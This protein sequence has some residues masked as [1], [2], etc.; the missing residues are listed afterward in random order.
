MR[1][2]VSVFA[3]VVFIIGITSAIK[4]LAIKLAVLCQLVRHV[5]AKT[6]IIWFG[7]HPR[8]LQTPHTGLPLYRC[9]LGLVVCHKSSRLCCCELQS[10]RGSGSDFFSVD[11]RPSKGINRS[12]C[13]LHVLYRYRRNIGPVPSPQVKL[14]RLRL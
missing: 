14:S 10:K 8:T 6:I 11:S 9:L 4:K 7:L 13:P 12:Q 5:V 1:N 2:N 3:S